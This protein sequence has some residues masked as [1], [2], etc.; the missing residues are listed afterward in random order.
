MKNARAIAYLIAGAVI[1]AVIG[2][3][4]STAFAQ[5]VRSGIEAWQKGDYKAAVEVWRTLA[6]RG[7]SD[8]MFNLAQAYRLGR[9]VPANLA[10]AKSLFERAARAGHLESQTTLGLLLLQGGDR[11]DG[12]AWLKS[13]AEAGE[14][15]ALLVYGT[16]LVNGDGV[17]QDQ[18]L[19]YSY[20]HSA[21]EAKL[22]AARRTLVE[23][24]KLLSAADRKK[25]LA[26]QAPKARPGGKVAAAPTAKAIG[27]AAAAPTAKASGNW[28]IQLGAFARKGAA[29]A[30]F[31]KVSGV[32]PGR[33]ANYLPAGK[34]TRL[35]VG[36]FDSR[37]AAA[38]ACANLKARD[39]TC[40]VVEPR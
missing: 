10:T 34:V 22:P 25:A 23:L 14:P 36:P 2:A 1:G 33:Q 19:G 16:A 11:L 24:D 8:A 9:G 32:L 12:L 26:Q 15:R 31:A 7:N 29:E 27:K 35:Q 37:S 21:A 38:A 17:T 20:V 30:L 13:A 18:L 40:L 4:P 28:R 6:D 3:A 39:R 5:S